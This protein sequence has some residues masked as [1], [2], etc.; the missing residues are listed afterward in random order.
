MDGEK[1]ERRK[2]QKRDKHKA[3]KENR[4]DNHAKNGEVITQRKTMI[5]AKEYTLTTERMR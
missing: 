5:G 4:E 3:Y 1:K 2:S